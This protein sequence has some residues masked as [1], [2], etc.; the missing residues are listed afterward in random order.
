M[1]E[2]NKLWLSAAQS[3]R[4]LSPNLKVYSLIYTLLYRR[5]Q[6]KISAIFTNVW[7]SSTVLRYSIR[8]S[9]A[10]FK[11]VAAGSYWTGRHSH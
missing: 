11:P 1:V 9:T 5:R 8:S 10:W 7:A 2:T 6:R 4:S 3:S